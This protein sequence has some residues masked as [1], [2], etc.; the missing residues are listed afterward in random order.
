MHLDRIL[1]YGVEFGT[2]YKIAFFSI[3]SMLMIV[4]KQLDFFIVII[5]LSLPFKD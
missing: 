1:K 2:E 3:K 5:V 4:L